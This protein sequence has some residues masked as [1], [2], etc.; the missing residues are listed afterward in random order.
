MEINIFSLIQADIQNRL[1]D[2]VGSG[3]EG[4]GGTNGLS[5]MEAYTLP[6]GSG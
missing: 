2:M 5:D 4:E 6:Y 3:E 1:T